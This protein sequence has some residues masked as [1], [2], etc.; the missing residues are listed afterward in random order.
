M[1]KKISIND[2]MK[3]ERWLVPKRSEIQHALLDLLV[4]GTVL[5]RKK[6]LSPNAVEWRLFGWLVGA[7]F[8]LW[9][10]VF[11]AEKKLDEQI[12]HKAARD[13][14][15]NVIRTNAVGFQQEQNSWSYGYYLNNAR[16]RLIE[17]HSYLSALQRRQLQHDIDQLKKE[18]RGTALYIDPSRNYECSHRAFVGLVAASKVKL[19][20][21]R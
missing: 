18:L 14:L 3:F 13:F 10:A 16:F 7:G 9:R 1:P 19:G 12:N 8:S 5:A 2:P 21:E 11:T 17:A 15:Q 6:R 20:I 4:I